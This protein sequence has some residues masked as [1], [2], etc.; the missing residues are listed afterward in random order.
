MDPKT[1]LIWFRIRSLS[2][3]Y[4]WQSVSAQPGEV[5]SQLAELCPLSGPMRWLGHCEEPHPAATLIVEYQGQAG[6]LPGFGCFA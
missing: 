6:L 5:L 4:G 3:T 1:C 2:R